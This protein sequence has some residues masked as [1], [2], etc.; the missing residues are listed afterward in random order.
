MWRKALLLKYTRLPIP[1]F[2]KS[3]FN[4]SQTVGEMVFVHFEVVAVMSTAVLLHARFCMIED[5]GRS[6]RREVTMST[7]VPSSELHCP[8]YEC[9]C[10]QVN[11]AVYPTWTQ[12]YC[13]NFLLLIS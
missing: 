12:L 9:N 7:N 2:F 10:T 13:S 4:F 1:F 3:K 6:K 11:T 8:V 5:S